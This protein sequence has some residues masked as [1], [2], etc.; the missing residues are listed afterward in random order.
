MSSPDHSNELVLFFLGDSDMA[1]WPSNQLPSI[2]NIISLKHHNFKQV[3]HNHSKNGALL[4]DVPSQVQKALEDYQSVRPHGNAEKCS[5]SS[6]NVFF[7]VCAGENDISNGL[8]IDNVMTSFNGLIDSIFSNESSRCFERRPHLI[9]LGPKLEPWLVD[10]KSS[11]KS[12]FQLSERMISQ[13]CQRLPTSTK[14]NLLDT[15]NVN[16]HSCDDSVDDGKHISYINC[17]TMFCG[18]SAK[19]QGAVLA[20]R[21][22][23]EMKYFNDDGLHLNEE[24]YKVWKEE[25]QNVLSRILCTERC[26]ESLDMSQYGGTKYL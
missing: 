3:N 5:S 6:S 19:M 8:S 7:I 15:D 21:A 11:R 23:A 9:F 16:N 4:Q 12:Y 17:L 2:S 14:V 13:S 24:G 10:D 25:L 22:K 20:G 1:R 18:E 26:V